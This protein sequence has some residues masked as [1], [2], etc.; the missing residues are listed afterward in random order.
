[1]PKESLV[2]SVT[3]TLA[4]ETTVLDETV[5]SDC[6]SEKE[7][8]E[9]VIVGSALVTTLPPMVAVIWTALPEA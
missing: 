3:V 7:P 2:V 6:V 8:G 4:P 9:T 5:S 1:M